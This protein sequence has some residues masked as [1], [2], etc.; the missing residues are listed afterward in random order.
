MEC[1]QPS[2]LLIVPIRVAELVGIESM[3][4]DES[5]VRKRSSTGAFVQEFRAGAPSIFFNCLAAVAAS[6]DHATPRLPG[7]HRSAVVEH[8]Q[9]RHRS[10]EVVSRRKG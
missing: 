9:G 2:C 7:S 6:G 10:A 5:I 8:F 3:Y 4:E 1:K